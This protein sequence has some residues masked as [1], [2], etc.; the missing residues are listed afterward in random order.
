M[1]LSINENGFKFL[2]PENKIKKWC[3][4]TEKIGGRRYTNDKYYTFL[5]PKSEKKAV[6][7]VLTWYMIYF[8]N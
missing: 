4:I 1:N 8:L 7:S 2:N 5:G 3:L 6:K